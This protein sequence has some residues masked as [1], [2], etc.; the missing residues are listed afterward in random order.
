MKHLKSVCG[1]TIIELL[2]VVAVVAILAGLSFPA[3]L[4]TR[5]K[6]QISK[7]SNNLK[8]IGIACRLYTGDH[9]GVFPMSSTP[10]STP[11]RADYNLLIPTYASKGIFQAPT[12]KAA[13]NAAKANLSTP[14]MTVPN[15]NSYTY[16]AGLDVIA[17][18]GNLDTDDPYEPI[19]PMATERLAARPIV[20][21]ANQNVND[22]IF[23]GDGVNVLKTDGSVIFV[24][25]SSGSVRLYQDTLMA[26][27]ITNQV[28]NSG[29]R[30]N[31]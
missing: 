29:W 11:A 8:N 20:S 27:S 22:I 3:V 9:G 2:A 1:F 24:N 12:D 7:S 14:L 13:A 18:V 5:M 4:K 19:I 31:E 17:I 10:S 30:N 16:F 15:E 28:P 23:R 21:T 25:A 6:A 26:E